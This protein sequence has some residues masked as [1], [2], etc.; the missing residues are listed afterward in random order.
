MRWILFS[1]SLLVLGLCL[2][3]EFMG[4]NSIEDFN[5]YLQ[6]NV[7][8]TLLPTFSSLKPPYTPVYTNASIGIGLLGEYTLANTFGISSGYLMTM[9][10]V[11]DKKTPIYFLYSNSAGRTVT[12]H[13]VPILFFY[14]I[15]PVQWPY[16][17]IKLR[18]G[19]SLDWINRGGGIYSPK[20]RFLGNVVSGISFGVERHTGRVMEF[21]LNYVRSLRSYEIEQI[22]QIIKSKI[23]VLSLD[24]HYYLFKR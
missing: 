11:E 5:M 6:A 24:F 4:R 9:Q 14:K 23:D 21:G 2:N 22:G 1:K 20:Y 3:L 13:Q 15:E 18:L 17:Y 19:T 8:R 12:Y 7:G 16:R 10:H